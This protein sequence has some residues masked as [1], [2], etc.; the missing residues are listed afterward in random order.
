M[1]SKN[2]TLTGRLTIPVS[3]CWRVKQSK[4]PQDRNKHAL[5]SP[6]EDATIPHTELPPLC[7]Y[8][9]S[10]RSD[11]HSCSPLQHLKKMQNTYFHEKSC[12]HYANCNST[13]CTFFLLALVSASMK[14]SP[15]GAE[16]LIPFG[17]NTNFL[18]L[19]GEASSSHSRRIDFIQRAPKAAGRVISCQVGSFSP[20]FLVS[21]LTE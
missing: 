3:S 17:G 13:A 16:R 1:V 20:P 19:T 14:M 4:R 5:T 21:P 15:S 8:V 10:S 9:R 7:T 6:Q 2:F 18:K 12:P 11:P